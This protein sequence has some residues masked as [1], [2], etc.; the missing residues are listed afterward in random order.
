MVWQETPS[1]GEAGDGEPVLREEVLAEHLPR[2]G[3]PELP[4]ARV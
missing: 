1:L 4:L 3:G 2:M